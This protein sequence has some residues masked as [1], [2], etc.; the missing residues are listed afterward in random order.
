MVI[1]GPS[2]IP[3]PTPG[4]PLDLVRDARV[5]NHEGHGAMDLIERGVTS[6]GTP[7]RVHRGVVET[8]LVIATGCIR[9]ATGAS[10]SQVSS[11]APRTVAR[12]LLRDACSAHEPI[13]QHA[14]RTRII[15]RTRQ[16]LFEARS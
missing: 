5:V 6:R 7:M 16:I 14:W 1:H 9:L 4:P 10:L 13:R 8:E 3:I 12:T 15:P 11:L 2:P